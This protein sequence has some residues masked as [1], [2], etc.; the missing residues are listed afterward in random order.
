MKYRVFLLFLAGLFISACA[1]EKPAPQ[2]AKPAATEPAEA[3]SPAMT[4]LPAAASDEELVY[5]PIDVSK[6]DSQWWRQ[7]SG[8]GG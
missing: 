8:A 3:A 1:D 7:Y 2:A 5:D 6:L 4:E